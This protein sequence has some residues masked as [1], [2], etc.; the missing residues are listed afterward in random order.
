M[1]LYFHQRDTTNVT[2]LHT[3]EIS[4]QFMCLQIT[5]QYHHILQRKYLN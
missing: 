2:L 3:I 4:R 1:T 5:I